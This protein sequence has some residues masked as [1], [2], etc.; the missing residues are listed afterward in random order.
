MTAGAMTTLWLMLMGWSVIIAKE[1][2]RHNLRVGQLW[3]HLYSGDVGNAFFYW[4]QL[5]S[6]GCSRKTKIN[7]KKPNFG[8]EVIVWNS[9]HFLSLFSMSE[10]LWKGIVGSVFFLGLRFNW[11]SHSKYVVLP[12]SVI[13]LHIKYNNGSL[14]EPSTKC[15][16]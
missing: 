3:G 9:A 10:W 5:T 8:T 7:R 2:H 4:A 15:W 1:N 14:M 11:K 6:L 12:S 16:M 13:K